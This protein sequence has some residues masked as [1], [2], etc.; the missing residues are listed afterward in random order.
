MV[1]WIGRQRRFRPNWEVEKIVHIPLN[2]LLEPENY[3]RYRLHFDTSQR[4]DLQGRAQDFP[5]FVHKDDSEVEYL[6]GA[7]YR[8]VM[9]F[10]DIIFGFEAP[11]MERLPL[12][13]GSL[14]QGYLNGSVFG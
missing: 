10:L 5:C 9:V 14:N 2:R 6:W 13:H 8:I 4:D 3:A 1:G 11:S 12:V 7:T